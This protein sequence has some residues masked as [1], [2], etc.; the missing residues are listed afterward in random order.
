MLAVLAVVAVVAVVVA[1]WSAQT[2]IDLSPQAMEAFAL[3]M[4]A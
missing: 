3:A 4:A 1:V 2:S